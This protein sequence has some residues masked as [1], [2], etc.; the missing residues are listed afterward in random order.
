MDQPNQVREEQVYAFQ[1]NSREEIRAFLSTWQ[2]HELVDLRVFARKAGGEWVPTRKGLTFA[3]EL[4]PEMARAVA[5]LMKASESAS[6]TS[7]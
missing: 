3:R 5:E 6:P 2:G 7:G 4:I 1:K